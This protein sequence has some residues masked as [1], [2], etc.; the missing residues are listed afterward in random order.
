VV[1]EAEMTLRVD[2]LPNFLIIGAAKAG[3]TTLYDVLRQHPQVFLPVVKEPAFFCDDDYFSQGTEWYRQTFYGE[4]GD[5]LVRGEATSTYLYWG[6]KVVPRLEGVYGRA[7]PKIIVI[8]RDPV[9]LV[10]S[11]YWHS[12]RE[13]REPLGIRPALAA[14]A[15]R[16]A[17][18]GEWLRQRGRIVYSYRRIGMYATQLEPYLARVPREQCLFLLTDDLRNAEG[19]ARTLQTFLALDP[20]PALRPVASNAAAMPQS[21]VLHRWLRQRSWVKDV[22]KPL[23]SPSLR[24]AW[25]MR[26]IEA[27]LKPFQ[28]PPLDADLADTLRRHYADEMKRLEAII[29]RDLSAWYTRA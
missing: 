22:L 13:G 25:K 14:E 18:H 10:H 3:T 12:V 29:G 26:A 23:V 27:N 19:L 2:G 24:H 8:F 1:L 5:R 16:L 15:D 11:F 21:A 9:A 6:E 4:A 28:A 17:Q 7:L 20:Q